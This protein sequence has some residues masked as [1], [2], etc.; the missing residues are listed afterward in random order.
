MRVLNADTN[1]NHDPTTN[2]GLTLTLSF[3]LIINLTL[4]LPTA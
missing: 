1:D 3:T 2:P 4:A